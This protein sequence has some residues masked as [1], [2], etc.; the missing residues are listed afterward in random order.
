[1]EIYVNEED[2]NDSEDMQ[3]LNFCRYAHQKN[4]IDDDLR[5][6]D[7]F[8]PQ[9]VLKNAQ[10]GLIELIKVEY[11]KILKKI[12][13][14]IETF[15]I[16]PSYITYE[17]S[18]G[19]FHHLNEKDLDDDITVYEYRDVEGTDVDVYEVKFNGLKIFL[20]KFYN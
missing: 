14:S 7:L 8:S 20:Y 1:M 3:K 6:I 12:S 16:E 17:S 11:E 10:I 18:F 4:A 5:N 15:G 9:I 2:F 19:Y 13:D